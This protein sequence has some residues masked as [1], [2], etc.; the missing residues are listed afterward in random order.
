MEGS[1]RDG[2]RVGFPDAE[3]DPSR[4]GNRQWLSRYS[5]FGY[6]VS[7]R[8]TVERP[9]P[10]RDTDR[11]QGYAVS[12]HWYSIARVSAGISP[13]SPTPIARVSATRGITHPIG[14]RLP[15]EE[16]PR[17][18]CRIHHRLRCF[19]LGELFGL[20]FEHARLTVLAGHGYHVERATAG[21]DG[22]LGHREGCATGRAG[23][24]EHPE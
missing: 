17:L 5:M 14:R 10:H 6:L 15:V 13:P 24:Q 18:P 12:V 9:P 7:R 23:L 22:F 11:H 19:L 4:H 8:N 1:D 2:H 20:E 3:A 16:E 21:L